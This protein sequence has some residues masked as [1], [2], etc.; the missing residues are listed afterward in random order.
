MVDLNLKDRK[1]EAA[2]WIKVRLL[3]VRG[4]FD[5]DMVQPGKHDWCLCLSTDTKL[6]AQK[7]LELYAM[8]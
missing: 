8:R 4:V 2:R 5:S 1:D 6:D 3:F 7:M